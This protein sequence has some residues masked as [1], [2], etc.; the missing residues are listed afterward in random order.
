MLSSDS[1]FFAATRVVRYASYDVDFGIGLTIFQ[2]SFLRSPP[3]SNRLKCCTKSICDY[4]KKFQKV[5]FSF[6]V[7]FL[8]RSFN[9]T[10]HKKRTKFRSNAALIT[11]SCS[12]SFAVWLERKLKRKVIAITIGKVS[13]NSDLIAKTRRS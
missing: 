1:F 2:F 9:V 7:A 6:V 3:P 10:K 8:L 13:V 5:L 12:F 4:R 11:F